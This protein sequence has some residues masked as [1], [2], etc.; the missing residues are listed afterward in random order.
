MTIYA[1]KRAVSGCHL[2]YV[3]AEAELIM[4]DLES[5]DLRQVSLWAAMLC[6]AV[7]AVPAVQHAV[8][9]GRVDQ[10]CLNVRVTGCT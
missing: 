1:S 3:Q 7:S 9:A 4:I 2:V 8:Q 6:V 10:F 5:R